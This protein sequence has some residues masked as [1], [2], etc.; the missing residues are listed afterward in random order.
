[1]ANVPVNKSH[2]RDLAWN[3]YFDGTEIVYEALKEKDNPEAKP[4]LH[5]KR[6]NDLRDPTRKE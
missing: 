5:G 1:M 2:K 3:K 4:R 6:G